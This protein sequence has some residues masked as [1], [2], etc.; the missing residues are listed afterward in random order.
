MRCAWSD[1]SHGFQERS[2]VLSGERGR[3]LKRQ[4]KGPGRNTRLPKK[5]GWEVKTSSKAVAEMKD[6]HDSGGGRLWG[7][8]WYRPQGG[9]VTSTFLS[10]YYL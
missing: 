1:H 7:M 9:T 4:T 10:R 3:R 6:S 5:Q 2:D 8:R